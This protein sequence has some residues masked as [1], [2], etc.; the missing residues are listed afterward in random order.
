M[1]AGSRWGTCACTGAIT[2]ATF[3]A[4]FVAGIEIL[5]T[6]QAQAANDCG[7]GTNVT[8]TSAGNPYTLGITYSNNDQTV[9]LQAGAAVTGLVGVSLNGANT[10]TLNVA[11]G[12]T[13][14]PTFGN[15]VN[16]NNATGTLNINADGSAITS[17]ATGISAQSTN[18]PIS[19]TTGSVTA[20]NTAINALVLSGNGAL[21]VTANGTVSGAVGIS[22]VAQGT[23]AVRVTTHDVMSGGVVAQ[24]SGGTVTVDSTAGTVTGGV[25]ATFSGAS[26][27]A[28]VTTASVN[29]AGIGVAGFTG[30]PN[31]ALTI[32]TTAGTVHTTGNNANG[33]QA[34]T[35][36]FPFASNA[37]TNTVRAGNITTDGSGSVGILALGKGGNIDI[38]AG[39]AIH[40]TGD[41][42]NTDN[43]TLAGSVTTTIRVT[44]SIVT[45]GAT[46]NGINASMETGG[47]NMIAVSGSVT[48]NGASGIGI[49]TS[50]VG[51][52][53][54]VA[55]GG[56]V[57]GSTG[58]EFTASGPST[59]TNSG[60]IT[61]T[62]GTAVQYLTF[63]SNFL[64]FT[65]NGTV[66]G[67][68]LMG[69]AND[70][71]ILNTGSMIN[72]TLNGQGGS[73]T[74]QLIGTGTGTLD[75]GNVVNFSVSQKMDGGT[76]TLTGTNAA[77]VPTMDVQQGTLIVNSAT[78]GMAVTVQN[79]ARLAGTGTVG[80]TQINSGG[81]LAPGAPGTPGTS[82]AV[83]GN[84]AFASG[85]IYLVALNPTGMT[86]A[87]VSGSAALAGTVDASFASGKYV[88]KR[89]TILT[90]S[91]GLV[92]TTFT[93]LTNSNLP[94]GARDTLSYDAN[95]VYLNLTAGFSQFSGL[96]INQQ[97]V[98]N[99]LTNYFNSNGSIPAAFFNLTPGGL[100]QIDGEVATGAERSAFQLMDQFL[101]V[102]LDPFVD[103]RFGR[104]GGTGSALS[105][106]PQEQA[107]LPPDIAL[108]YASILNKA[109]PKVSFDQRWTT[110]GSAYA[111]SNSANGDP[112]V[113]GS[114]NVT[115]R[116]FGFAAGMD[117]RA[118][119]NTV[120]GFALAGGGTGWGLAGGLGSGRSDAFQAGVYGVTRE[121]P[122][123]LAAALSFANH[124]F[125]TTRSALGDQL[126][127]NFVGQSY[128][129]RLEAG[130]RFST[131]P[132]LGVTPYTALQAQDF[133]TPGYS[134]SDASGGGFGL[135]YAAMNA[136]DVRTEIGSR[137]DAPTLV[138][139]MP[140]TLRGR[141]AWVHDFVTNPAL[142]AVFQV[143]PGSNFVV[144]GAPIPHDSALVSAGAE[145]FLAP[146]WTLLTKFDSEFARGSQTYAGS[147]TLRH[148]W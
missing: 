3:A 54:T 85:A 86:F 66:N 100:T 50:G 48:A 91:G 21:T 147:G 46:A 137:L 73:N 80:A 136:I 1:N 83:S 113:V 27:A 118:T 134:E 35:G 10:Q 25:V 38:T 109:P 16:I 133:H 53:V 70:V 68:V 5:D 140:L 39:G 143:L 8:C 67:N 29:N 31:A 139:G 75:V 41:G 22:A 129:T 97:N 47:A 135:S 9:S 6:A 148:S 104:F 131:L 94:A 142:S 2:R 103:G 125:T 37:G 115:A 130:Y 58:V 4:I 128:G 74:L 45:S 120:V 59:L 111:G 89:Y 101:N 11:P 107:N 7:A 33:I 122:A 106:A 117:Y 65:N 95:D 28:A 114:T 141:M 90:A 123:Y 57:S 61:G 62:G 127:T 77:F 42:I 12:V 88:S 92:G 84:L 138:A 44:G 26:G 112:S 78:S 32:D 76:W 24:S 19:I 55:A 146:N 132:R 93:G 87:N 105:F 60:T 34:V 64:T 17:S 99:A 145:L 20:T 15:A 14:N 69:R 72:G 23:G 71:A 81:T 144:N 124:W 36:H 116:T 52:S 121:G 13:I 49:R 82:L 18:G 102:M 98:A 108:A 30:G 119:P 63:G 40:S 96:N 51:D 56:S 43:G 126:N 110:W 79:G